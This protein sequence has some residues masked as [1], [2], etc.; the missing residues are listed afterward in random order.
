MN[1]NWHPLGPLERENISN[2]N[3]STWLER[4]AGRKDRS[5]WCDKASAHFFFFFW[6]GLGSYP[7]HSNWTMMNGLQSG[8]PRAM[9]PPWL[10]VEEG[11]KKE[12]CYIRT[13]LISRILY[14]YSMTSSPGFLE[15]AQET[16]NGY[17]P[18]VLRMQASGL[19]NPNSATGKVIAHI[20]T[21]GWLSSSPQTVISF[22]Q[23]S[24]SFEMTPH[25]KH[26]F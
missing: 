21:Q 15:N 8:P 3:L 10:E 5:M 17:A 23:M 25:F 2:V 20:V 4:A 6:W 18:I 11:M 26:E 24:T 1:E 16:Y 9:D 19:T 7:C 14:W 22:S 12:R 13:T